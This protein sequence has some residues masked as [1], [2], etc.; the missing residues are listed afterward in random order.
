MTREVARDIRLG[1]V[2]CQRVTKPG[3]PLLVIF[4]IAVGKER[5]SPCRGAEYFSSVLDGAPVLLGTRGD[6]GS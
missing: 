2:D 1:G 5:F 3:Q 6:L 4:A